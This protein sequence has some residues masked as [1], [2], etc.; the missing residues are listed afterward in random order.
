MDVKGRF[1]PVF[2]GYFN[3]GSYTYKTTRQ[4]CGMAWHPGVWR[5]GKRK[6]RDTRDKGR[7]EFRGEI[8]DMD[9]HSS[10][11]SRCCTAA[12]LRAVIGGGRRVEASTKQ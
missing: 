4:K 3:V 1:V 5:S 6:C 9:G 12:R 11:K 8:H 10:K 2:T 7:G